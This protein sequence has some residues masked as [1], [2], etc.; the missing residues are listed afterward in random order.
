M[1]AN[2]F[3]TEIATLS[4]KAKSNQRFQSNFIE[5]PGVYRAHGALLQVFFQAVEGVEGIA[6][7]HV[8]GFK[9]FYGRTQFLVLVVVHS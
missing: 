4:L 8:V 2:G 3:P 1:R 5:G 6:G 7:R 9:L